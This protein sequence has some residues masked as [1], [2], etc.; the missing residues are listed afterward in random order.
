[1]TLS[2]LIRAQEG[3]PASESGSPTTNTALIDQKTPSHNHIPNSMFCSV[4]GSDSFYIGNQPLYFHET[5]PSKL[6]RDQEG[7]PTTPKIAPGPQI[8]P[9][10]AKKYPA[11]ITFK[12]ARSALSGYSTAVTLVTNISMLSK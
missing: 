1:M 4:R 10:L 2:K 9:E 7:V 8:W 11:K 5:T 6:I 3:V 12:T